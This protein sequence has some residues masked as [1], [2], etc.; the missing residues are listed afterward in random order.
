VSAGESLALLIGALALLAL[1]FWPGKGL[2]WR[3]TG[4]LGMRDRVAVEDALKHLYDCE[5]HGRTA[6][7]ESLAGALAISANGASRLAAELE[8][9][10][11]AR[12]VALGLELTQ[13]GRGDALRVIRIHRLW[14][15]YLAERTGFDE[16]EW[17]GE[18]DRREHTLTPEEVE[19]LASRLGH[20]RYDPHGDPIPTADG[21][22]A[23]A[24]GERLAAAHQGQTVAIVHVEDEPEAIYAQLVAQ[25]LTPG[26]RL[27]I[28]EVSPE[29]IG[30]EA[31]GE[32]H[33]LAPVVAA[34]LTVVPLGE[35]R[36]NDLPHER[37]SQLKPGE[38]ARVLGISRDCRAPQ[39]RR[40]LDLGL[41]PGTP[42]VA[43]FRSPNGDPTAYRIRGSLIALRREEG[44][45]IRIQRAG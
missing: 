23:P 41:V 2:W 24:R 44:E 37:L 29:R 6:T 12:T 34:N 16:R 31:R 33:V 40:L 5:Y 36:E 13:E 11:L 3:L 7:I 17:H 35:E 22:I 25:R 19:R 32:S 4:L 8:K 30:F 9:L 18:A 38:E 42:V 45:M 1:V 20:P 14:E 27:R 28:T 10:H 43:E 26:L 15:Q 39:M 21:D